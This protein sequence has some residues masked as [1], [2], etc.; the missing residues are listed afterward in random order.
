LVIVKIC[1][2]KEGSTFRAHRGRSTETIIK[3]VFGAKAFLGPEEPEENTRKI[4]NFVQNERFEVGL[5]SSEMPAPTVKFPKTSR[6]LANLLFTFKD[7]S[8]EFCVNYDS[9][10]KQ[11]TVA[12]DNKVECICKNGIAKYFVNVR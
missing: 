5:V 7:N 11:C 4:Y 12:S 1:N 6:E 10:T 8:C 2:L 9:N 3:R